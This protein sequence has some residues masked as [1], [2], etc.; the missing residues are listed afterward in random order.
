M[1]RSCLLYRYKLKEDYKKNVHVI[2]FNLNP[3][4]SN[5]P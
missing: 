5:P 2:N 4:I 1:I 3:K